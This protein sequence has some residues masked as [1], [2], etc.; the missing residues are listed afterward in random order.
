MPNKKVQKVNL[1]LVLYPCAA[2][3]CDELIPDDGTS[4]IYCSARCKKRMQ[5]A[6]R[7]GAFKEHTAECDKCMKAYT[8]RHPKQRFCSVNCSRRG[9]AEERIVTCAN[10]LCNMVFTTKQPNQ[11]YCTKACGQVVK[12]ARNANAQ[13]VECA[14]EG[15]TNKL[16]LYGHT[17]YCSKACNIKVKRKKR[18]LDNRTEYRARFA[19]WRV[20]ANAVSSE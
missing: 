15:C 9:I 1:E 14:R 11:I 19:Q 13:L 10:P 8:R 2:T 20:E 16:F 17:V 18:Y 7:Q 12:R 3:E 6:R 5:R 4:K